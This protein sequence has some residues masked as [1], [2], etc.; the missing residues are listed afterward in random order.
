MQLGEGAGF[1]ISP[2]S[3]E[4]AFSEFSRSSRR[5]G[6]GTKQGRGAGRRR[7]AMFSLSEI[8][9]LAIR[10]EKNGERFYREARE[11]VSNEDLRSMLTRL[12]DDEVKHEEFFAKKKE[13]L[14]LNPEDPEMEEAA[15]T[16][17]QGILGDQT[18]SLR[19]AN[20]ADL[21]TV[22]NLINLAIEFEKDTVL[23][24]EVLTPLVTRSATLKGLE[25][26]VLE[27]KRHIQMLQA[28]QQ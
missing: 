3:L 19:E 1:L 11:R 23:F 10:I 15:S 22:E 7:G 21:K 6:R 5:A 2:E 26:I 8:Y 27:E 12:A 4:S 28:F 9:D 16:I 25:E 18:F 17:L 14:A 13:V 24:Y 20:P